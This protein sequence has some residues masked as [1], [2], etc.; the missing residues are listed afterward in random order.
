[1]FSRDLILYSYPRLILNKQYNDSSILLGEISE[2]YAVR[3]IKCEGMITKL[4]DGNIRSKIRYIM[5]L[6]YIICK[7]GLNRV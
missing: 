7:K 3:C 4:F 1:M 5:V 6:C 2:E